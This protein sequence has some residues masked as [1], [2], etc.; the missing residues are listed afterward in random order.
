MAVGDLLLVPPGLA[1]KQLSTKGDFTLLG[2]YPADSPRVDTL[3]GSPTPQQR[4]N[5]AACL[6]PERDPVFGLEIDELVRSVT[7][8]RAAAPTDDPNDETFTGS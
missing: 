2:S 7:V 6:V 8:E 4:D 1:H 3:R 5:I